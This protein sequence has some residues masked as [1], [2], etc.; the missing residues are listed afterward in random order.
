MERELSLG[1]VHY[2]IHGSGSPIV[3]LHGRTGDVGHM[4]A[5]MEPVYDDEAPWQRIYF[6]LPWNGRTKASNE[7]DSYDRVLDFVLEFIDSQ[8]LK[9]NGCRTFWSSRRGSMSMRSENISHPHFPFMML[10]YQTDSF[11]RVLA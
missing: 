7:V 8:N 1:R 5:V 11:R 10:A 2:A 4:Q 9:S 3:V 6:D